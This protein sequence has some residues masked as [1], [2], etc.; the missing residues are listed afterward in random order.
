MK[1]DSRS[2]GPRRFIRDCEPLFARLRDVIDWTL[3]IA[4][5]LAR[6]YEEELEAIERVRCY[7]RAWLQGRQ[8]EIDINDVL[9]T[10][11]VLF[12]AIE[13]EVDLAASE[14][15]STLTALP[16]VVHL[17]GARSPVVAIPRRRRYRNHPGLN[18][19]DVVA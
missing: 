17:P 9:L 13:I 19:G 2:A 3:D 7:V 10:L 14:L 16:G 1:Q 4:A 5:R 12:A 6:D 18:V 8:V 11:A 15:L